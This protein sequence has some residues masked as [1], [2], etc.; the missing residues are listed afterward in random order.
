M[1]VRLNAQGDQGYAEVCIEDGEFKEVKVKTL[2]GEIFSKKPYEKAKDRYMYAIDFIFGHNPKN[3][4]IM[5]KL[6][7]EGEAKNYCSSFIAK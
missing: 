2:T 6:L 4:E 3:V 7:K 1:S 5:A